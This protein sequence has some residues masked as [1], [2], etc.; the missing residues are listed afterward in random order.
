MSNITYR[1]FEYTDTDYEIVINIW[2]QIWTDDLTSTGG[3]RHRDKNRRK[4]FFNR[5]IAEQNGRPVGYGAYA[6][7]WWSPRPGKYWLDFQTAPTHRHQGIASGFYQMALGALHARGEVNLLTVHTRSDKAESIAFL[8][9]RDFQQVMRYPRSHLAVHNFQ[10]DLY[11]GLIGQLA[12]EGVQLLTYRQVEATVPDW[13][14]NLYEMICELEKDIP[15]PEPLQPDPFDDFVEGLE[16]NPSLLKDGYYL[17]VDNGR[18]V[19]QSVLWSSQANP[20]KLYTGLTGVLRSHRR[21]GVA[22]AL[23]SKTLQFAQQHGYELVETDNEENN[24]M[25]Q[26]NIQLG[27]QPAPAYLDFHKSMAEDTDSPSN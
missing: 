20:G 8:Q 11:D 10:P 24:P 3:L 23:K 22:T 16:N 14:R 26:I 25:Y 5:F 7:T 13:Q 19:G 15:S 17:A 2:N 12:E 27:F 4:K 1:P 21:R 18:I 9:H 6:E